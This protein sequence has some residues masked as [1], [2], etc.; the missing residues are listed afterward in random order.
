MSEIIKP[1]DFDRTFE[2]EVRHE[3][4]D[5]AVKGY[6]CRISGARNIYGSVSLHRLFG[7]MHR[8]WRPTPHRPF[9]FEEER[10]KDLIF[11]LD[12]ITIGSLSIS[13]L[14]KTDLTNFVDGVRT[15]LLERECAEMSDEHIKLFLGRLHEH[16]M[17]FLKG[18]K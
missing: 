11:M 12:N 8:V 13:P 5:Y 6:N 9:R 17:G 16:Y 1:V 3:G 2:Y 10:H 15:S 4:T 18:L 7:E 14:G